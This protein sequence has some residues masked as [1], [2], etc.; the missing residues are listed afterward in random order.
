MFDVK[1]IRE[2]MGDMNMAMFPFARGALGVAGTLVKGDSYEPSRAGSVVYFS[3]EDIPETLRRINANS[4]RTLMPKTGIGEYGY[5]AH[6]EDTEGN[7]LA[8]HSRI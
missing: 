4:G 7:R 5:I 2:D 6:F 8:L 1:L 3:A